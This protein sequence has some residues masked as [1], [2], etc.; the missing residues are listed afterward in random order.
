MTLKIL[1]V[2]S[3][4]KFTFERHICSF[5]SLVGQ[6]IGLL[7][8]CF[9]VFGDQTVLLRCFNSFIFPYLEHCSP[10]LFFTADSH[11]NFLIRISVLVNS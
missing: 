5:S 1:G 11:F 3:D 9:R 6:K 4:S 7:E 2:M 8:N 10:V